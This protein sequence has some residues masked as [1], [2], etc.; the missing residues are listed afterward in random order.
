MCYRPNI[1]PCTG[2]IARWTEYLAG[3][4]FSVEH[5]AG[6]CNVVA[7][8]I[9]RTPIHLDDP[10]K[11]EEEEA[12]AYAI[13][14]IAVAPRRQG[15]QTALNL[16]T[17]SGK[18]LRERQEQ[19]G[20]LGQVISWVK[21]SQNPPED[22]KVRGLHKHIQYYKGILPTLSMVTTPDQQQVLGQTYT[23]W[24]GEQKI[25]LAVPMDLRQEAFEACHNHESAGH[26]GA[27]STI[28]RARNFFTYPGMKSDITARCIHCLGCL[29]KARKVKL[30]DATH[31][32]D[33]SAEPLQKVYLD[34]YGPLPAVPRYNSLEIPPGKKPGLEEGQGMKYILTIEDDWSRFVD[35]VPIPAKDAGTVASGLMDEFIS[36]F[37]Y[38]GELYSDQGKEFCNQVFTELGKLGKYHHQFSKPYNPQANRVERFHRTLGTMLTVNLDRHDVNWVS[39]LQAI[40]LAYNT[41]VN[42]ATGVTPALAF[43]GH[44]LKI[45]I[46][47]IVPEPENPPSKYKWLSNLQETYSSI[48]NRMYTT[49]SAGHRSNAHL[50][51]N[52]KNLFS[53]GDIVWHYAKRQV[54]DK[55]PKLTQR[56]NGLYRVTQVL[57]EICLEITAVSDPSIKITTTVH[58]VQIYKGDNTLHHAIERPDQLTQPIPDSEEDICFQET[59][60]ATP[61]GEG[62]RARV[63]ETSALRKKKPCKSVA[64]FSNY[65]SS[66]SYINHQNK[67]M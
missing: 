35:L 32:P 34:L 9:S 11:E 54:A 24:L 16:E 39:K 67:L 18:Q 48:F 13:H 64:F 12:T 57:N 29:Q 8:A 17:F 22:R 20:V 65:I 38:P 63:S 46:S 5:I 23:N 6:K 52:K 33:R 58:Y 21:G 28:A 14:K 27:N 45:P 3:F 43:L 51:S 44:E 47:L 37:G 56:W 10:S 26:W 42:S 1:K 53:V 40:K 59:E 30:T 49:G 60:V 25:R 19:D 4:D 36:R 55:P 61:M 50:Y 2:I 66:L 7:D 41:R 15:P 31:Q 62:L